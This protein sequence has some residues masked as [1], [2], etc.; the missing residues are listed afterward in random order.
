MQRRT[1]GRISAVVAVGLA[2]AAMAVAPAQASHSTIEGFTH[3]APGSAQSGPYPLTITIYATDTKPNTAFWVMAAPVGSRANGVI[4]GIDCGRVSSQY[5]TS[6][7]PFASD[8]TGYIAPATV[9]L[10][11][12]PAG[13]YRVCFYEVVGP[14][15]GDDPSAVFTWPVT[16]TV[17][18]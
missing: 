7:G 5:F 1:A 10:D 4:G 6:G 8:A 14:D 13:T 12:H 9:T 16:V 2:M 18:S 11:R 17:T 3:F 15:R